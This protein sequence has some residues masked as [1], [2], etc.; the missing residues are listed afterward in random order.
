MS[1]VG[2]AGEL[3]DL[4][5]GQVEEL[6]EASSDVDEDLTALLGGAALAAGDVA[7]ATSGN[8]LAYG[9]SPD[10]DAE[11]GLADVDDDTH[12]LAILLVL[13]GLANSGKHDVK[14]ELVNGDV[15]LL[16]EL[17]RPLATMLVLG[18]LPLGANAS[19]EE[20]VVGLESQL[21]DGGDV[22]LEID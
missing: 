17:V 9:A 13:E 18:V 5:S 2:V 7:V 11:E 20:M 15:T 22:V 1:T 14:P 3:D 6:L 19:L 12:D 8:A 21:G 4:T 10:A 16:L